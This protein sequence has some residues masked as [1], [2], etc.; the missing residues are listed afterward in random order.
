MS[1]PQIVIGDF[2]NLQ[3]LLLPHSRPAS[4]DL[5]CGGNVA[6]DN[7]KALMLFTSA[8]NASS[9]TGLLK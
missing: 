7:Q 1:V 3:D 8:S 2:P 5:P 9:S 6:V 4:S